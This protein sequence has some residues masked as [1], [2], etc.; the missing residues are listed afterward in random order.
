MNKASFIYKGIFIFLLTI[1]VNCKKEKESNQEKVSVPVLSTQPISKISL[2]SAISG[3]FINKDGGAEVT[4]RGIVWSTIPNPTIASNYTSDG[5]GI[6]NYTSN[7]TGLLANTTYFVRAYATNSKG[8][9]YG[10]EIS[11]KTFFYLNPNLNYGSMIDQ[12]GNTYA[13]IKIGTQEW[14]AENLRTSTYRN[15]DPI[16]NVTDYTS[17]W[18]LT[19]GA[20][21]H[22]NNDSQYETPY[23]KLYNWYAV[24][25]TRNICPFGWHVPTDAEWNVLKIYLGGGTAGREMRSIGTDYWK[26][27]NY[28]ATN[29]SG[30]S[31]LPGGN[32]YFSGTFDFDGTFGGWWSTTTDGLDYAR[33]RLLHF[34]DNDLMRND[35]KKNHGYSVRCIKD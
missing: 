15:G 13:T 17:Y 28:D 7:L 20:W 9:A 25:D 11:F 6:G 33:V 5:K 30:F 29:E 3:G 2:S 14:M 1:F 21:S 10:E 12:D 23:G 4:Q 35:V 24:A 32:R 8:T 19:S 34:V 31:G 18:N 27:P 16:A 22:I 26:H